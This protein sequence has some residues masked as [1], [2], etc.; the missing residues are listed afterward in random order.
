MSNLQK[1][2]RDL[3]FFYVK[4]NYNKYLKDNNV[5]L[6]PENKIQKVIESLY[7]QKKDHLQQFIKQSL[8]TLLKEDCPDDLIILNIFVD[9]FSDDELCKNRLVAEIK[10]HQ[11]TLQ[12]KVCD[13]TQ[14]S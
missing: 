13:Y 11:Q 6:I 14:L 3:I 4:E 1:T 12:N 9:I 10:L 2:I 7:D 8:K 5:Q